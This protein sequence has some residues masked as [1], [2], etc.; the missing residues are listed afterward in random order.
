MCGCRLA[1]TTNGYG[2]G[3]GCPSESGWGQ[4]SAVQMA[5]MARFGFLT[6][7]GCS[8]HQVTGA[9]LAVPAGGGGG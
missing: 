8:G 6:V 7:E 1:G 3:S 2:V 5:Q 4:G 9:Q